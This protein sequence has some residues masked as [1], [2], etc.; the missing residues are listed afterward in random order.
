MCERERELACVCASGCVCACKRNTES[1]R[2]AA[3]FQINLRHHRYWKGRPF[4]ASAEHLIKIYSFFDSIKKYELE[5]QAGTQYVFFSQHNSITNEYGAVVHF[6]FFRSSVPGF[7][8][9]D[10]IIFCHLATMLK[11][12]Q[13][14]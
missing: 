12:Q 1:E 3:R 13:P 2:S 7:K 9:L 5:S 14:N 4:K 10:L 6:T 11:L 8:S